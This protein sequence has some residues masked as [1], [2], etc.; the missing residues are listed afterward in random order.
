V[1]VALQ[2]LIDG[3]VL[4]ALLAVAAAGLSLVLGVLGMIN[5]AHGD[6]LTVGAF[7]GLV[8]IAA[9]LPIWV[10][11]L[12]A[13]VVGAALAVLMEHSLWRPLRAR[14]SSSFSLLLMSVGVAYVL[15]YVVFWIFGSDT[16]QYYPPQPQLQ[17]AGAGIG[18]NQLWILLG[19]LVCLGFLLALLRFT[20]MGIAMRAMADN[21]DLARASGIDVNSLSVRTWVIVGVMT[22]FAGVLVGLNGRVYPNLGWNLILLIMAAVIVGGIGTAT[23]AIAGAF[24][25][26]IAQELVTHPVIGVPTELKQAAV[27]LL[28]IVVLIVRPQGLLG[29]RRLI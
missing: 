12:A 13:M 10:A 6:M 2:L 3:V 25:I 4:G 19:S 1:T 9:G 23:G 8:A 5:V 22:G 24:L 17:I 29:R 27:F 18:A 16:R 21:R 28:L 11:L 26:G 20:P 7:T 14:G 15:R